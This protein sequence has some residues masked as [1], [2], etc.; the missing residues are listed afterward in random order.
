M[1]RH[2]FATFLVLLLSSTVSF[3]AA[4]DDDSAPS[5]EQGDAESEAELE[6]ESDQ[7]IETQ[8]P[9]QEP[10]VQPEPIDEE[11]NPDASFT[12]T[13]EISEDKPVAFPVDI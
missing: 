9:E 8:E 6:I 13:E 5:F 10:A 4:Q 1:L 7:E 12:P 11:I 3:V 2:L